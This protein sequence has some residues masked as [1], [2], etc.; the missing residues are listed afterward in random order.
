MKL[1]ELLL[2]YVEDNLAEG[3]QAIKNCSHIPDSEILT[4]SHEK[5]ADYFNNILLIIDTLD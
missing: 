1:E 4:N 3:K 2:E 5:T